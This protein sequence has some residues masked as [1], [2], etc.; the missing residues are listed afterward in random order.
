MKFSQI[1]KLLFEKSISE[2]GY[3]STY[4]K[5]CLA[6]STVHLINEEVVAVSKKS[7]PWRIY[8]IS[9]CQQ[10]FERTKKDDIIFKD[11]QDK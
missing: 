4:A 11:L 7:N 9:H 8:L 3:A 5:L 1:V 6:L 2:P 10:E